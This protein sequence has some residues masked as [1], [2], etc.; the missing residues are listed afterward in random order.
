MNDVFR[1]RAL[2][3]WAIIVVTIIASIVVIATGC[4]PRCYDPMPIIVE[5]NEM[6]DQRNEWRRAYLLAE[7]SLIQYRARARVEQWKREGWK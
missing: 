3:E 2:I 1:A 6:I 7:D 4:C 5:H